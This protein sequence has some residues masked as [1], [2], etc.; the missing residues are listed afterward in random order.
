MPGALLILPATLDSIGAIGDYLVA[1][2]A[3][4]G[5]ERRDA[6]RLRLAIDELATNVIVHGYQENGLTGDLVIGAD[7][8]PGA[9]VVTVEDGAPAFDP[10]SREM[11]VPGELDPP[12]EDP[13]IGGLGVFLAI[14]SVE[15]FRYERRG[16][17]NVTTI[18]VRH[19]PEET[20]QAG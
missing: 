8:R 9:V 11:P 10:R 4:A 2:A 7:S 17:R 5:L 20:P 16:D 6:Y 18:E 15:E 3:E 19:R 12:L 1:A 13:D 14:K